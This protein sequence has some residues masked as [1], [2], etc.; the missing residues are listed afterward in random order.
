M[1]IEQSKVYQDAK[2]KNTVEVLYTEGVSLPDDLTELV[3]Q[4]ADF[5]TE[6]HVPYI[7]K[8]EGGVLVKVGKETAHPMTAEHYIVYIEIVADGTLI[9]KYLK[10]GDAPQAYFKTDAKNIVARELCSLHKL[11]KSNQ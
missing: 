4:T 9:R 6:K 1:P 2:N 7:E 3:P 8:A 11:W 10:P 5:A